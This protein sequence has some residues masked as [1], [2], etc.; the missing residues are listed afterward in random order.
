MGLA[1]EEG[2]HPTLRAQSD[3]Q[4]HTASMK[5]TNEALYIETVRCDVD[6]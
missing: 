6:V 4:P 2:E 5:D 3:A 1:I